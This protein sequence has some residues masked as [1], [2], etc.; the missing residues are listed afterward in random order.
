[1]NFAKYASTEKRSGWEQTENANTLK[2]IFSLQIYF[3]SLSILDT[4]GRVNEQ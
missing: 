2:N 3:Q 1:M 4:F